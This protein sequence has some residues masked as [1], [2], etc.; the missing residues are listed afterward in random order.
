MEFCRVPLTAPLKLAFYLTAA[1]TA[2]TTQ[3]QTAFQVTSSITSSCTV[4]AAEL[5]FGA[6]HGIQ[7]DQTGTITVTC[8]RGIPYQIGLDKGLH[9]RAPD[10]RLKHRTT[11]HYLN[12]ELYR[13]AG[14]ALDGATTIV[15]ISI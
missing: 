8:T 11:A 2:T 1:T 5:D 14:R 15:A 9:Y 12:Y 4:N 7:D 10:R 3:M 6:Y 13:D